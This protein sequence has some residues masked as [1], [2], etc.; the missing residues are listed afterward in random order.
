LFLAIPLFIFIIDSDYGVVVGI[1]FLA[2]F[3]DIMDGYVARKLNQITEFGK[4][5]DPL[6][7]KVFVS[8]LVIAL[9][10]QGRIPLWFF[11]TI[12][13]RDI[14]ILLGGMFMAKR[15]KK[16]PAS[17][18]YGKMAVSAIGITLLLNILNVL[19]PDMFLLLLII[20][21]ITLAV[22]FAVY[23]KNFFISFK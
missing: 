18:F 23:L 2:S 22:S 19:S 15:Q 17:N 6:A 12:A 11:L 13:S 16:V 7:D 5:I 14:L 8:A 9:L 20:T 21:T 1:L 3:T 4:V 10:L